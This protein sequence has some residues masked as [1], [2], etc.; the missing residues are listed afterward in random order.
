MST[1]SGTIIPVT[2]TEAL[3]IRRSLDGRLGVKPAQLLHR[4]VYTFLR[5]LALLCVFAMLAVILVPP[6][7]EYTQLRWASP[8]VFSLLPLTALAAV[9]TF[10]A[11]VR[12][13]WIAWGWAM[14]APT[15][16]YDIRALAEGRERRV[17][18]REGIIISLVSLVG[19]S[20]ATAVA[21]LI[22]DLQSLDGPD[23]TLFLYRAAQLDSGVSPVF[24]IVLSSVALAIL[25]TWQLSRLHLLDEVT[26][27]EEAFAPDPT[28]VRQA[29]VDEIKERIAKGLH[30]ARTDLSRVVPGLPAGVGRVA[31]AL[32]F[33]VLSSALWI[34]FE[35]SFEAITG[36]PR[37]GPWTAFDVVFRLSI[38]VI[39][40]S[41]SLAL[42]RLVMVWRA[43][44]LTLKALNASPLI[45][46]FERLPR[47]IARLT[48]LTLL[49][50]PARET[51]HAVTATQWQ[52]LRSLFEANEQAF[53]Q[54]SAD[55]ADDMRTLMKVAPS[56]GCDNQRGGVTFAAPLK[57]L[58]CAIEKL[59]A[60][61][62][63]IA[64]VNAVLEDLKR[65][66]PGSGES[67]T[68]RIR[69]S[70]PDA[71]RLWV[72]SAEEFVAVQAVDY[73]AWTLHHLRRLV[74]ML[75]FMLVVMMGLLSSYSFLPQSVV[76]ALFLILFIAVVV[77][78]LLLLAQMNRDEVLSRVTR[79]DP[80]RL[81]WDSG[82]L[83]NIGTV[84]AIP[85]LS[86]V[87]AFSPLRTDLFGWV[88][89]LLEL[90]SKH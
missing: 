27:F 55:A 73:I 1:S 69:R 17:W 3:V 5:H 2:T 19:L 14:L 68:G 34:H 26:A 35:P 62:P 82:F 45:T 87:S 81:T 30:A 50:D 32:L 46:A 41:S 40:V 89:G 25:C 83:F 47:R 57:Q 58:L 74:L 23:A 37:I 78:L 21:K 16:E 71:V 39:F 48:R 20:Y 52:H 31:F 61:E 67:A 10:G 38:L 64:Q 24:P 51:V 77:S 15:S 79:T 72:R 84:V 28:K 43:L 63:G 66:A 90:L 11:R 12:D 54:V 8:V 13:V 53:V 76:R 60:T 42:V 18:W 49:A 44:R 88:D 86:L 75:L 22:V 70:A 33:V 9:I 7:A 65:E 36:L 4:E 80:G 6:A 56:S 29:N 85:I 59:W